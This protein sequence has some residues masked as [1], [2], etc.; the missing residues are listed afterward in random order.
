VT[1]TAEAILDVAALAFLLLTSAPLLLQ[2]PYYLAS[3]QAL[4]LLLP[5]QHLP[6]AGAM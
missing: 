5:Q 1:Y 3:F 6:R 4:P 2:L